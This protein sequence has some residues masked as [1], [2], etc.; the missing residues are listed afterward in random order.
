MFIGQTRVQCLRAPPPP[1]GTHSEGSAQRRRGR[2]AKPLPL[3][4]CPLEE[5]GWETLNT[6]LYEGRTGMNHGTG[7]SCPSLLVRI[8]TYPRL[9]GHFGK[10]GYAGKMEEEGQY[11]MRMKQCGR[12][13]TLRGEGNIGLHNSYNH[14]GYLCRFK[15]N[16]KDFCG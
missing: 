11:E 2:K 9:R 15:T 5:V 10:I 13:K 8:H 7:S 1:V 16:C 6:C 12:K 3:S 4:G 14:I